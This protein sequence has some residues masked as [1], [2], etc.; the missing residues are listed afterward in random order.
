MPSHSHLLAKCIDILFS[1]SQHGC[2]I[3][4]AVYAS[5]A[6]KWDMDIK[7]SHITAKIVQGERNPK[8][9][10]LF[11]INVFKDLRICGK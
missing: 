8:T 6:A 1:Q 9:K 7:T 5:A 10:V 2:G 3:E 4:T 11:F